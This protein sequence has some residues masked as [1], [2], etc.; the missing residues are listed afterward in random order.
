M[1]ADDHFQISHLPVATIGFHWPRPISHLPIAFHLT[2]RYS[3]ALKRMG[4]ADKFSSIATNAAEQ[5]L[6]NMD[7]TLTARHIILRHW[8][9]DMNTSQK[10]LNAARLYCMNRH[11][12]WC[13]KYQAINDQGGARFGHGYTDKAYDTFPRYNVLDAI[14]IDIERLDSDDLPALENLAELLILAGHTAQ[15]VFIE[16]PSSPIES[17]AIADERQQFAAAI[18]EL[19]SGQIP[20]V[21][22]LPYRRVLSVTEVESLWLRVKARWGTDGSYFYPLAE[23]TDPSL[24]AFDETAFNKQFPPASL[25]DIL[26]AQGINRLFELREYGDNNYR[27]S[28]DIWEPYYDGAEGFWFTESLDWIMYVSH[29]N[30]ITTGG[31]LTDAV[32]KNWPEASMHNWKTWNG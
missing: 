27:L 18:A 29:E 16:K 28:I 13:A 1:V 19:A 3:Y 24:A 10:L 17:A 12:H 4:A 31:T 14:L 2:I 21:S 26:R 20:D 8:V 6:A 5:G 25:Q 32:M 22:A 11:A 15:S 30:T 9:I 23:S 7:Y